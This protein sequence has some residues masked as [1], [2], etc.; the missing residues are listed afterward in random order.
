MKKTLIALALAAAAFSASASAS[1]ISYNYVQVEYNMFGELS[2]ANEKVD[3]F[4]LRGSFEL[5]ENWY[6]AGAYIDT[7][8]TVFGTDF[9]VTNT[10]LGAGWHTAIGGGKT[11]YFVEALYTNIDI[12]V[13][14]GGGADEDGYAVNTGV[15]WSFTDKFEGIAAAGYEDYG[16]GLDG[17]TAK[18]GGQFKFTDAFGIVAEYKYSDVFSDGFDNG[19]YLVGARYSF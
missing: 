6:I 7:G 19:S 11:D 12:E 13:F 10:Q 1:E 14:G 9:D 2:F 18:I 16:Q 3:G 15:R 4:G 17:F 8:A 5:G